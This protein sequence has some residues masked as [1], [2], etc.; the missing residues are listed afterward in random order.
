MLHCTVHTYILKTDTENCTQEIEDGD[1][2]YMIRE[3]KTKQKYPIDIIKEV[4][5]WCL[6]VHNV[7]NL[8]T[9]KKKTET[10]KTKTPLLLLHL[11]S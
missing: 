11:C 1:G 4:L 8:K 7:N 3:T 2:D 6:R 9:E 5:S 10:N